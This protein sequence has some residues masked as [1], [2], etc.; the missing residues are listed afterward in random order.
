MAGMFKKKKLTTSKK[1]MRIRTGDDVIVVSGAG[2]SNTPRKVL[3]TLP[4]E[5]KV[6]VEGVNVMKDRQKGG[7]GGRSSGINEQDVIEKPFP[8]DASNVMLIDPTTKKRTRVA[9]KPQADSK[10]ARVAVKSGEVV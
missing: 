10:R 8:I 6:I 1:P 2:R 4:R 3:S 9:I 7:A 5:G